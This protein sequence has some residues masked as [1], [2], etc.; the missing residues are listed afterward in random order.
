MADCIFCKII[1]KEI[2]KQMIFEDSDFA[3]FED[4]K[5]KAPLHILIVPKV[6]LSSVKDLTEKET[7][8]AG[9]LVILAKN[10]AAEKNLA[11]YK[12]IFNVGREGG[13]MIDHLH[14]HLVGGWDSAPRK[15]EV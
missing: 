6:H 15:V 10:I 12:L 13:Q 14:L 7:E 3:A 5:P 2:P 4:I 11:G 9:K 1:K 8:L